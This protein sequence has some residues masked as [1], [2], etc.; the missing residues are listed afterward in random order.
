MIKRFKI[1]V[2]EDL[3]LLRKSAKSKSLAKFVALLLIKKLANIC[4]HATYNMYAD[5]GEI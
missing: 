3:N 2:E 1:P 4:A 5:I